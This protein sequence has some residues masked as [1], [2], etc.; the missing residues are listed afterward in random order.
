MALEFQFLMQLSYLVRRKVS[1]YFSKKHLSVL[2]AVAMSF[3]LLVFVS[4]NAAGDLIGY[5]TF[6]DG[7][8]TDL[9][10]TGND[11]VVHGDPQVVA[12]AVGDAYEFNGAGDWVEIPDNPSIS[13]LDAFT[14]SAHVR[15]GQVGGWYAVIEKAVHQ[16]WSYGFF[17]EA[18]GS[19]SMEVSLEGNN[20]VCC[21]ADFVMEV[22]T[23]YHIVCIYDGTVGQLYVDGNLEGELPASGPVNIT[24]HPLSIG[25]R[26]DSSFFPGAIDEV[27]L[28]N[29]VVSIADTMDPLPSSAVKPLDKLSVTWGG[30]K[31]PIQ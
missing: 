11:G 6:D 29:A 18:D 22:G 31:N 8:V 3:S 20:L 4:F 27:A 24:T 5:W 30:I 15:L 10:G 12:G 25:S 1:M 28:W 13:E 16:D 9:S 7:D 23:W 21:I 17:V 14:L 26:G 2:A 19:V